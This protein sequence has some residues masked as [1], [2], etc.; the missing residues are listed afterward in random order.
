MPLVLTLRPHRGSRVRI[1]TAGGEEVWVELREV[2]G[3]SARLMFVAPDEVEILRESL[4]PA[5][6]R[7]PMKTS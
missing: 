1:R 3:Q 2:D 5:G 7:P 4:V 6:E